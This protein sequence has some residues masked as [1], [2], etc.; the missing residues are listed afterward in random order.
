M[1][2][3]LF[4]FLLLAGYLTY[5]SAQQ[6]GSCGPNLTWT[7]DED[8]TLTIS[9][10]GEMYEGAVVEGLQKNVTQLILEEGITH[11][12]ESA[13]QGCSELTGTLILPESLTSIG[14]NAFMGCSKLTGN[15]IL[16]ES[17]TSIGYGAFWGCSGFT[18]PLTLH[19]GLTSIGEY[20]FCICSGFTGT[21][22]LPASLTSI[23][24][25]V[26]SGCSGFT[27]NLTLP[28]GLTSIGD[29]AF[30]SCNGFTGNL[31]LPAGLT[32]I[33]N[34]SFF[35]CGFTDTLILP[36]DLLKIESRAFGYCNFS[37]VLNKNRTPIVIGSDVFQGLTLSKVKLCV[38]VGSGDAYSQAEVWK[39]F[40]I[41]EYED[42]TPFFS[43][44]RES[45]TCGTEISISAKTGAEIYYGL[46]KDAV[47]TLRYT[48]P[49]VII[50]TTYICAY[51]KEGNKYS[52]TVY[53]KYIPIHSFFRV[54]WDWSSE[55]KA[56]LSLTYSCCSTKTKPAVSLSEELTKE[57]TEEEA[58]LKTYTAIATANGVTYKS[59]YREVLARL[60][61]PIY[62][63]VVKTDTIV[64]T[65]IVHDTVVITDT[66]YIEVGAGNAE[67]KAMKMR[68]YPNPTN[69]SFTVEAEEDAHLQIYDAAGACIRSGYTYG[70]RFTGSLPTSGLYFI[71]LTSGNRTYTKRLIVR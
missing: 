48:N 22:I 49:I 42:L 39:E 65:D 5:A 57:A 37:V 17:L 68:L 50:D 9:G 45:I 62:D 21:L 71:K 32:S 25:G 1:K 41:E 19:E 69:G 59:T 47:P 2:K 58:G 14:Q 33:G 29:Y 26:F 8:G 23:G 38:P 34:A 7:L 46:G 54:D 31:T 44:N 67:A 3:L 56:T 66:V 4:I 52:E 11:I 53:V 12:G 63:T 27:G 24:E 64:V 20:A 10:T 61:Q 35:V 30:S 16:P 36:K 6:S 60:S 43:E 15:L 51:S 55:H 13:F 28:M 70:G 40:T 18:G